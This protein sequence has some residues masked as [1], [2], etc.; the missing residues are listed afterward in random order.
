[1]VRQALLNRGHRG[2]AEQEAERKRGGVDKSEDGL[3]GADGE[4]AEKSF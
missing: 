3:S 4:A 1:M 2:G